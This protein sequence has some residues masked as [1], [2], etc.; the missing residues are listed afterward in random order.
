MD[1]GRLEAFSDGVFAVAIT[2]LALNLAVKGPGHGTLAS[3]L[4]EQWAGYVAY[5]ISFFTIG[6][7]W[8]NHHAMVS[9]VVRVSRTLLFL[10]LV[11]LLFV[12]LVPVATDTVALYLAH[13]G[14]DAKLAVAMYGVVL[15]G[16]SV[17]FGS[18]L[19]WS[20]RGEGRMRVPVPPEQ[21]WAARIRFMSGALVYVLIIAIAFASAPVALGLSGAVAVYYIF[22]WTPALEKPDEPGEP[23]G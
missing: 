23:G 16:M 1:R 22:E 7:I 18:M 5:V 15:L 17:G 2:L 4:G 11:L 20:L 13:G 9:N 14:F 8:V 12:V 19:E 10:N 21:R 3:Q 6:V